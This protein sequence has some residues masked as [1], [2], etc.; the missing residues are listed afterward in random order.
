MSAAEQLYNLLKETFLLLDDGDRQFFTRFNLTAPRY[1]ALFHLGQEPGISASQLSDR[2]LCDKSNA[3][4]IVQGLEADGYIERKPHETD[5][6]TLR[7]FL[8][9]AGTAVYQQVL[10]AHQAYNEARF[11]SL[12]QKEQEDLLSILTRLKRS[13]PEES[14]V[15]QSF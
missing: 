9:E 8:T 13:L 15:P 6:R 5:G 4:R 3:S 12:S 11:G 14:N 7:L 10:S 2:M 1:Y